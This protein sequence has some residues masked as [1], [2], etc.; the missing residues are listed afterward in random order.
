MKKPLSKKPLGESERGWNTLEVGTDGPVH[1]EIC[2]TDH[3]ENL[4]Q[5]YWLS[6]FLGFQV[7][8]SCCGNIID[9]AYDDLGRSFAFAFLKEFAENPTDIR[10]HAFRFAL[11]EAM[12]EAAKKLTEVRKQ[13]AEISEAAEKL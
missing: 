7:V 9:Q 2:G 13:V 4:D 5:S 10:F 11:Q 1:C 3:P 6:E 8:D 12:E